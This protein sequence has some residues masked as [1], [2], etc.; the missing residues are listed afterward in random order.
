MKHVGLAITALAATAS[1]DDR[2]Q[3]GEV[4]IIED[5]AVAAKPKNHKPLK[6][7]PY[8]DE[9]VLSDAWTRAW[10]LLDV[11]ARG[12]VVRIKFLKHPGYDLESIARDEVFKLEFEPARDATG[13]AVPT[14][15]VW[16]IEWPSAWWLSTFVGTRS[17]MPPIVGF[18]PQRLDAHVPCA[19]SGPLHLGS[20]HP[21]YKDCSKPDLSR[22]AVEP[23][24]TR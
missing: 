19:G 9:A 14:R 22:A 11:D 17:S 16:D 8:S 21:V 6:A 23:W 24:V 2:V 10:L 15:I 1:A 13:K 18:P 5:H 12:H 20:V 7:P 3:P 4:I